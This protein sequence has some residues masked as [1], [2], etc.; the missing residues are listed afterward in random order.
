MSSFQ[1]G[2][3]LPQGLPSTDMTDAPPERLW[4]CWAGA[5]FPGSLAY[6]VLLDVGPI[7]FS[8]QR[9][10]G[11]GLGLLFGEALAE[12]HSLPAE[13][14][15]CSD[16]V[17][18]WTFWRSLLVSA[19]LTHCVIP[20]LNSAR[21]QLFLGSVFLSDAKSSPALCPNHPLTQPQ[22]QSKAR[23][24]P[25]RLKEHWHISAY[26]CT[27][28]ALHTHPPTR[29]ALLLHFQHSTLLYWTTGQPLVSF[30]CF[31]PLWSWQS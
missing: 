13:L 19:L 15:C 31:L 18:L 3:C 22:F 30:V 27:T 29:S 10:A 4:P 12:E 23:W 11:A 8:S 9:P 16:L 24:W 1:C 25:G 20:A 2:S 26:P 17:H 5:C 6:E 7:S 14:L 28:P 21:S